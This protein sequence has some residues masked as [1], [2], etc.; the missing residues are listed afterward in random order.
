MQLQIYGAEN[1]RILLTNLL[2]SYSMSLGPREVGTVEKNEA[3]VVMVVDDDFDMRET[4]V[5]VLEE[6]QIC[7][8]LK[9]TDGEDA[10][11]ILSE[12]AMPHLILIDELMPRMD[13]LE[14]IKEL[15]DHPKWANIPRILITGN[16]Q[17]RLGQGDVRAIL[18][19]PVSF[20]K[21]TET[22]LNTI[23]S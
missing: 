16:R 1:N 14:L 23:A 9:A 10:L 12:G 7:R 6:V 22:V 8:V 13:G 15:K 17:T 19:K 18:N 4:Y 20:E 21:L 11:R 2:F 3:T 5:T